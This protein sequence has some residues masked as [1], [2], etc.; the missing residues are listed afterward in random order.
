MSKNPVIP[1][2]IFAQ[3]IKE[4]PEYYGSHGLTA[5]FT[6]AS[7]LVSH[8]ELDEFGLQLLNP[9]PE[10]PYKTDNTCKVL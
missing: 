9:I 2:L 7:P 8:S 1:K 10:D 6:R 3:L 4:L 5:T